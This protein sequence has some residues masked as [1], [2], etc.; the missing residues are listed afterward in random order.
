MREAHA[1][2]CK[3]FLVTAKRWEHKPWPREA[4][5][6]IFYV[7]ELGDVWNIPN[8]VKGISYL[9]RSIHFDRIVP[10]DDYD[11]E[12]AA[13]LRE[14][15][16]VPGMGD[17]RVRYFRDKLAMRTKAVDDDIPVPEFV[18][19]LNHD[20]I[21]AFCSIVA[22]PW[23]LKPRS[24]ASAAGIKKIYSTEQLWQEINKMGDDQSN[25]LLEQ[26]VPGEI[27]HVDS[28]VYDFEVVFSRVHKYGR[29]PLDVTAGGIFSTFNLPEDHP[30]TQALKKINAEVGKSMG[31][32]HG[33]THTEF[34]KSEADGT[35]H[36][37]ETSARV[38]GA[39]ISE[40]LEASSGINLWREWARIEAL[41][42]ENK[43]QPPSPKQDYSGILICLARQQLP[44]TSAYT[45]PEIVWRL[46][47]DYHAGLI[48][49]SDRFDRIQQLLSDYVRR[50]AQDFAKHP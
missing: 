42:P 2:G 22:P 28:I 18:H 50:F 29:A 47:M 19:V 41:A 1:L 31:L 9:A 4:L 37:L 39:H 23:V 24:Q 20:R 11:L 46:N 13:A 43:Y 32:M 8:L 33:V 35:F 26:F 10:L 49:K 15:L 27:Y 34:I 17:T 30:E 48:V 3:V 38:G 21:Q 16:R 5:E 45:D 6:D 25:F 14:H 12:K 40:M 44:D 7:D 36:F